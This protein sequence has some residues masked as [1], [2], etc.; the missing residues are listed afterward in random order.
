MQLGQV[1]QSA[2]AHQGGVK[3]MNQQVHRGFVSNSR[4]PIQ[5][6]HIAESSPENSELEEIAAFHDIASRCFLAIPSG[7]SA[8]FFG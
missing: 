8:A 6:F 2:L 3:I 7:I 1:L 5:A 4:D